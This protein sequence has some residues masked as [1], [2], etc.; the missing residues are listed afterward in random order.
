MDGRRPMDHILT[1]GLCASCL[2]ARRIRTGKGSC[3][4]QCR[5]GL[6]DPRFPRY[7]RLPV[8]TCEGFE[9][10]P[11]ESGGAGGRDGPQA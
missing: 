10:A 3:F 7:P 5:R 4:W 9:P 1:V 6:T 11:A 2:H 8:E